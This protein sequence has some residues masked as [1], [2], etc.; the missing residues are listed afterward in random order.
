MDGNACRVVDHHHADPTPPCRD[1]LP[2]RARDHG[3][4]RVPSQ[5]GTWPSTRGTPT[6]SPSGAGGATRGTCWSTCSVHGAPVSGAGSR[7]RGALGA[8]DVPAAGRG[9][10]AR[11]VLHAPNCFLPLRRPLP[12]GGDDPRPRLRGAPGGLLARGRA[13][14]TAGSPRGRR[15]RPSASSAS[16]SSPRTTS[17]PATASP[18]AKLRV[19]PNAPG[20]PVGDAPPPV[21]ARPYL[22]AVG[23]PAGEEEPRPADRG[24]RATLGHRPRARARRARRAP[25][26]RSRRACEA[27]GLPRRRGARRA[28][29]RRGRARPPV[30]LRG[31]RAG[32]RRGDGPRGARG[33][34]GR[35]GAARDRGRAP[36]CS[37]TR[38]TCRRSPRASARRSSAPRSSRVAGLRAR[39]GLVVGG[40]RRRRPRP[41]TRS[42][43][44]PRATVSRTDP[45][46]Q[47]RRGR[48]A[49]SSPCP[50]R[51]PSPTRGSSSSTTPA[52]TA[53]SRS[54]RSSA[55][56]SSACASG[57]PT[58]PR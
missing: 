9:A 53:R 8:G 40:E 16:R 23:R 46:A 48:T 41:S 44:E 22:L 28:H 12:R 47:R 19:I 49:S 1:R 30:A 27:T 25:T 55:S 3:V 31:L 36:R 58:P 17:S 7:P 15:A 21:R 14:S 4:R 29:A 6:P 52:R 42:S 5:C 34:R 26:A 37:S 33:L 56:S 54:A 24:V 57:A 38:F 10:T 45:R 50:P 18:A 43:R 39:A 35:D 20:L 11:A 2:F 51:W 13:R 32:G